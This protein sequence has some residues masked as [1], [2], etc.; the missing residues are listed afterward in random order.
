MNERPVDPAKPSP[1]LEPTMRRQLPV[2][3]LSVA[4]LIT[5]VAGTVSA[6]DIPIDIL[7]YWQIENNA[8]WNWIN[9]GD[10]PRAEQRFRR[11]I[12][13]VRPYQKHD[14]IVL[15][16]G[17]ADLARVLYHEGRY[18]EAEPLAKW[19]LAVRQSHPRSSPEAI[20]QSLYTLALIHIALDHFNKAEP[21]LRK[22]LTIQEKAIGPNHMQTAETI[23]EL[24][25]VCV[26]QRK[27][28]DAERLYKRAIAI[29]AQFNREENLELAACAE[30]YAAMLDQL[31]R[32]N[33][34]GKTRL[35]VDVIREHVK[36]KQQQAEA[37]RPR[38]E[39]RSPR[40]PVPPR[41]SGSSTTAYSP[42]LPR[43]GVKMVA[44]I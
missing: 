11:A 41:N 3:S 42:R 34:A 8:G 25:G 21:L 30:R 39:F 28:A 7:R 10:Y 43:G 36:N 12:E 20:F 19:A 40:P 22:A 26:Q 37:T 27:F 16:R 24:A 13:L 4:I 32:S 18:A 2:F 5:F 31:G 35:I 23:D 17:Y 44:A 15:A 29:Y 6:E 38:P 1:I 14:Q 33:D 9:K